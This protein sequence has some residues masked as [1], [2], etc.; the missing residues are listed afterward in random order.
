MEK[1]LHPDLA[2]NSRVTI[3]K[4]QKKTFKRGLLKHKGEQ[5]FPVQPRIGPYE[6][7]DAIFGS[8][9]YYWCSCGMSNKQPFCDSS[10]VGSLFKPLKFSL[11]EKTQKSMHLCGC[12]LSS[13]APFCDTVTCQK[14]LKGEPITAQEAVIAE[15]DY[16]EG[17]W[18]DE[19]SESA[20]A[21]SAESSA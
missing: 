9:N 21:A 1:Y 14:L 15:Q 6:I 18:N 3:E 2:A 4:Y 16:F 19:E 5:E 11:D 7:P 8:K 12:K 17:D 10:H 13:K 20:A